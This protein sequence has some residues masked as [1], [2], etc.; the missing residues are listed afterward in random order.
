MQEIKTKHAFDAVIFDI[1]G[2]L[3]DTLPTV[4]RIFNQLMGGRTGREL[5]L[6]DL[7]PYFGPPETE[8]IKHFFPGEEECQAVIE[9]FYR[10]SRAD[11]KAIKPFAGI[12]DLLAELR[13]DGL[14]LAV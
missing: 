11:G 4:V 2:T 10:L 5:S 3:A 13:N 9:E 8:I 12:R 1:D 6:D 14:G 7:L